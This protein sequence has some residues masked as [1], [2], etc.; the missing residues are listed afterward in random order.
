MEKKILNNYNKEITILVAEDDLGHADLIRLNLKRAG[1]KNAILPFEDGQ[2]IL[3]FLEKEKEK[4]YAKPG[5]AYLLLLDIRMPKIDGVEVLQ[6]IK[7]DFKLKTIPVIMLTTNDDPYEI[8]RCHRLGCNTYITKP[9][10]YNQFVEVIQRLGKFI[11]IIDI[12][13]I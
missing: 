7:S 10:E 3:D 5:K 2:E 9:I 12:P 1:I 6:R 8:S 4:P 11:K 13:E